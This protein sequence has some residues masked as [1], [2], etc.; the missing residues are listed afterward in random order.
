MPWIEDLETK[1]GENED[2]MSLQS[3]RDPSEE[4]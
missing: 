4:R 2:A 1:A 3:S